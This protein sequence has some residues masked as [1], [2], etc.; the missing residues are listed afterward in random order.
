MDTRLCW[1]SALRKAFLPLMLLPALISGQDRKE[2]SK[3]GPPS[4]GSV[5]R[6]QG[7][8]VS[9]NGSPIIGRRVCAAP[10]EAKTR[11]PKTFQAIDEKTGQLGARLAPFVGQTDDHGR[12]EIRVDR[13]TV[14]QMARTVQTGAFR[15]EGTPDW[16][17]GLLISKGA[18]QDCD[19]VLYSRAL[20]RGHQVTQNSL[21]TGHSAIV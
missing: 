14:L 11:R 13:D 4:S 2:S 10:L 12:F 19:N 1:S 15:Q 20:L 7:T 5:L 18:D 16:S 3:T 21:Q 17:I 9:S 8:L 6:L